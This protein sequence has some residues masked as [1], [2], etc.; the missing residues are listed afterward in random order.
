MGWLHWVA[1]MP[2]AHNCTYRTS[3][4]ANE[5][6]HGMHRCQVH[7]TWMVACSRRRRMNGNTSR[8]RG[9]QPT[10][11]LTVSQWYHGTSSEVKDGVGATSNGMPGASTSGTTSG[12]ETSGPATRSTTTRA[13]RTTSNRR[14]TRC[15]V[16]RAR[17]WGLGG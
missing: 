7:R 8:T 10:V 2:N 16:R 17:W 14:T 1:T 9:N 6:R 4:L 13:A 15:A 11:T 5:T 3:D 12:T